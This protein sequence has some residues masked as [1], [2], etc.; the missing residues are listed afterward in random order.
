L[1]R[2]DSGV[3]SPNKEN[4]NGSVFPG[5]GGQVRLDLSDHKNLTADSHD[6]QKLAALK[7]SSLKEAEGCL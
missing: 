7:K 2:S 3:E 1:V 4:K 6:T 5:Q